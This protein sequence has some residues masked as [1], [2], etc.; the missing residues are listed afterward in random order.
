MINESRI[1][2]IKK[3]N[4]TILFKM[5]MTLFLFVALIVFVLLLQSRKNEKLFFLL[6]GFFGGIFLCIFSYYL[7]MDYLPNQRKIK[8][9]TKLL[10][11]PMKENNYQIVQKI[12][13]VSYDGVSFIGY[14]GQLNEKIYQILVDENNALEVGQN[15]QL[16]LV[17]QVVMSGEISDD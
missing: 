16:K 7:L 5:L 8:L 17:H 4:K 10:S 12:G 13:P 14:Q 3:C 2:I 9:Y 1:T 15:Y 6:G 11:L